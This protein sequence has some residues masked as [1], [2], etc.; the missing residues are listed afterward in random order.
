MC[1]SD[2]DIYTINDKKEKIKSILRQNHNDL[3]NT[4]NWYNIFKNSINDGV[5]RKNTVFPN[6][7]VNGY[8]YFPIAL[9]AN[10]DNIYVSN[11]GNDNSYGNEINI[12]DLILNLVIKTKNDFIKIK[13]TPTTVW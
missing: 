13:L 9:A 8:I 5:L 4:E 10:T 7:S 3:Q 11:F 6:Q 12:N 2:L 1:S